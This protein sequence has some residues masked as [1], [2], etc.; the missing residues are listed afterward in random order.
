MKKVEQFQIEISFKLNLDQIKQLAVSTPGDR[1]AV[2]SQ[3]ADAARAAILDEGI[4][5]AYIKWLP[6]NFDDDYY[7]WFWVKYQEDPFRKIVAMQELARD[8][9]GPLEQLADI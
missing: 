4:R 3:I 8:Q 2:A 9:Y 7:D 5:G 6:D 1:A